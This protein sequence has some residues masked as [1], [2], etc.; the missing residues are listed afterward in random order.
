V[1]AFPEGVGGSRLCGW[2]GWADAELV[3]QP[4]ET[5]GV[6]GLTRA[7]AG[8]SQRES[9]LVAVFML[10]PLVD[11]DEQELRERHDVIS[12]QPS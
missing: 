11:P 6:H 8:N 4:G 10:F 12:G 5:F 9:G 7:A 3:D 2:C 1:L